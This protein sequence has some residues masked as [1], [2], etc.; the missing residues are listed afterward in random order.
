MAGKELTVV[1]RLVCHASDL[2]SIYRTRDDGSQ[3]AEKSTKVLAH[4][5]VVPCQA[6][7]LPENADQKARIGVAREPMTQRARI[8]N[9][10][11][12]M[13]VVARRSDGR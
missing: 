5:R 2:V 12:K 4:R 11:K 1:A 8:V 3:E 13:L 9:S 6:G 10:L 7:M